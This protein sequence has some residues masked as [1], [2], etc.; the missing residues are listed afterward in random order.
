L[1]D[2]APGRPTDDN[3]GGADAAPPVARSRA[4]TPRHAASLLLWRPGPDGPELLMGMRHARHRFMPN[5]LVFPGGR[6]DR[7]DYRCAVDSELPTAT[8]AALERGAPPSLARALGVAAAR[9]LEE[10]TG[11]VLGRMAGKRLRPALA[12][13]A[14]LCRAVTPPGRPIRF[15]ARFLVAPADAVTGTL[16]GSGELETLRYFPLA[17]AMTA[18]V[19]SI[20]GKVLDEFAAWVAMSDAEREA[21]PLVR[22][23]G[24]DNR[25]PER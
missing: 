25:V 8:R 19:A 21:R 11:L 2:D 5:V 4:V 1:T 9:E 16:R 22:F 17:E 7:A 24:M 12:G 18:R 3:P 23:A 6:V 15:N 20:T 14:Y 10:E 13:M